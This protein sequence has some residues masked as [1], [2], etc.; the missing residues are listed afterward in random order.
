M[1]E[2]DSPSS[3]TY[4]QHGCYRVACLRYL[5]VDPKFTTRADNIEISHVLNCVFPAFS[6]ASSFFDLVFCNGYKPVEEICCP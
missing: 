1:E 2:P 5:C 3:R 4:L 6:M